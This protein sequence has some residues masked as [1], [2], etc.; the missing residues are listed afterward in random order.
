MSL[1]AT[2]PAGHVWRVGREPNAWSWP[3]WEAVGPDGTF[4]NRWD[5]PAKVYRV[6]YAC[7]QRV[8]CYV[9]TLSRFRKD[10]VQIAEEASIVG[11]A[12]DAA[13][14]DY[15]AGRVPRSRLAARRIG[16]AEL[17]STWQFAHAASAANLTAFREHAAVAAA[18]VRLGIEDIDAAAVRLA[19]P[20]ELTQ[21]ISRAVFEISTEHAAPRFQG[22]AYA[23]RFGDEYQN[24]AI[25]ET[26]ESGA[27]FATG[28]NPQFLCTTV[29][30]D[31]DDDLKRALEILDVA[32]DDD[33]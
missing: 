4:G 28:S 2:S 23:S 1:E 29:D 33:R 30:V 15:P 8:A 10:I 21:A 3:P 5:D 11:D 14:L 31:G 19:K 9:E 27:F 7:T 16:W 20:R 13:F 32:V 6:L 17:P 26:P 25:F 18:A 12:R 22:I 24:W